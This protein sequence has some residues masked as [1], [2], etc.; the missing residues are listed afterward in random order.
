LKSCTG[1]PSVP[2]TRALISWALAAQNT[3]KLVS[4]TD[5]TAVRPAGT[6]IFEVTPLGS[7]SLVTCTGAVLL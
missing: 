1:V 3:V 6:V 7:L 4:S 5:W 2:S